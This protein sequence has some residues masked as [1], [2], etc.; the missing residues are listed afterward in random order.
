MEVMEH[1]LKFAGGGAEGFQALA[2]PFDLSQ[3]YFQISYFPVEVVIDDLVGAPE[4]L[5]E[6]PKQP[7]FQVV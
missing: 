4:L 6:P 3:N 2:G 1:G 7:G 5:G